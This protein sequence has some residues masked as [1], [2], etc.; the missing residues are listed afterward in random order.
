MSCSATESQAIKTATAAAATA[1][2]ICVRAFSTSFYPF[3]EHFITLFA[4]PVVHTQETINWCEMRRL[5]LRARE[6]ELPW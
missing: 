6:R 1:N 2:K 5:L 3:P 4:L